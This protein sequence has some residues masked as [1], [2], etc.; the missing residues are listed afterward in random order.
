MKKLVLSLLVLF[1]ATAISADE[2]IP[3]YSIVSTKNPV[4]VAKPSRA[5][6]SIGIYTDFGAGMASEEIYTLENNLSS[7]FSFGGGSGVRLTYG[8]LFHK[9]FDLQAEVSFHVS[10]LEPAPNDAKMYFNT[11][12]LS[13]TPHFIIP[14]TRRDNMRLKLGVGP[15][16]HF[17]NQLKIND[18]FTPLKD[19]WKYNKPF[20]YHVDMLYEYNFTYHWAVTGGFRWTGVNY[21]I[22]STGNSHPLDDFFIV[23]NGNAITFFVGINYHF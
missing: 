5:R 18:S 23:P 14:L 22:E 15:D 17:W 8:H 16:Y 10:Q 13:L 19:T 12:T 11:A 3:S 7:M 2:P 21:E 9:F 20:G 1:T 6:N 4:T